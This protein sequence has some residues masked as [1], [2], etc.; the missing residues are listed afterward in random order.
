MS[1]IAVHFISKIVV[2]SDSKFGDLVNVV[3]NIF[4][5]FAMTSFFETGLGI[6]YEKESVNHFMQ[7]SFFELIGSP[8]LKQGLRQLDRA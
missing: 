6:S 5:L 2:N 7:N 4:E 1:A 8:E 3:H